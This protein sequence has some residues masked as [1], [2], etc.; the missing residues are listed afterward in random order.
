MLLSLEVCL[1]LDLYVEPAD[2]G[3]RNSYLT[4]LSLF[5]TEKKRSRLASK[6]GPGFSTRDG[7]FGLKCKILKN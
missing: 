5:F 1:F 3:A 7:L 6:G 4:S 2:V